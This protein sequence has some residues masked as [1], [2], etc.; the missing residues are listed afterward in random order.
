MRVLLCLLLIPVLLDTACTHKTTVTPAS[1]KAAI[2]GNVMYL[3][4]IA[5][6]PNAV[7]QL[8]LQDVSRA[9]APAIVLG[10][11]TI[12]ASHQVPIPFRI[13]YDP[14]QIQESHTYVIRVR[15]TVENQLRWTNTTTTRVLTGGN[16]KQDVTIRVSPASS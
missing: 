2:T 1:L 7:V 5:L 9:D 3:E 16:P 4:R 14:S 8:E 15:I 13:E 11:E 12:A 10:Q 6:P